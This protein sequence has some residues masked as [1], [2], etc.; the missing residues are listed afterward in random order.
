MKPTKR[1]S[2]KFYRFWLYTLFLRRR[3]IKLK[4]HNFYIHRIPQP[5]LI[6][7]TL[8]LFL[9]LTGVWIIKSTFFSKT[10]AAGD[11]SIAWDFSV[12]GDYT[13]S[14]EN[15]VEVQSSSAR[16]KIREYEGDAANTSV[17]FNFNEA[18]GNP[19]DSSTN[20][21][22]AT[23]TNVTYGSGKLN[24][25]AIFSGN[26]SYVEV[27]DSASISLS[28]S[29]TVE[30]WIKLDANY[31]AGSSAQ[32]MG[33]LDK[34]DY[35]FGFNNETGKLVY[36]FADSGATDWS[37]SAAGLSNGSWDHNGKANIESSNF[38]GGNLYA[39][40][41][42]AQGDAEVWKWDGTTWTKIGGDAINESWAI[43]TFEAVYA[44][45]NDGTNLYVGL[46]LTAGE[47]EVWKWDGTSWSKIGGDAINNSWAIST[48]EAVYS[49][50]YQ[51]S[52]LY[53]G[54]GAGAS[55][56]EV[57]SWNG[58][59]WTKIGGDSTNS[60]WLTNYDSVYTLAG[61]G[62]NIYAGLGLT[63]TEAE[64]WK[65]NGTA[66]TKIGG[67]GLNSSW[68]TVY[69]SVLSMTYLSP[70]LYA[71]VGIT[72]S[73]GEV[74]RYDT[75]GG[76]WLQIGGDT[77]N[78][79]W[80][81]N[82]EGAYSVRT[83]G[84]D[85]YAGLGLTAADAELWKWTVATEQWSKLGGDVLNGSFPATATIV[86]TIV[87]DGSTLY[88][89]VNSG[90][91]NISGQMWRLQSGT[92]TLIG[93][94]KINFSWGT[95]GLQTVE[96][97][98][99]SEDKLYAGT[100]YSVA[101]NATVWEYDESTWN[102]VGGQG[103]NSS[104]AANTYEN[105]ISMVSHEGN[106]T[107]GLGVTAGEAEVW[108]YEDDTQTWTKV[109]GDT[110]NSSWGAGYEEV[111]SLSS[112]N[113]TLYAGIGITANDAE[114]WA[115]T[116]G[117]WAKI[118]GDT[119][120]SSWGAGYERVTSIQPYKGELYVGLG[121]TV[122]DAE[123]WKWDGTIWSRVGGDGVN[124]S[125]ANT[126]YESVDSMIIYGNYLAIGLGTGAGESEVWLYDGTNFTQI[127]GD[128]LNSSWADATY[129]RVRALVTYN[130]DLY[131]GTGNGTGEGE[132][133]K[134]NGTSWTQVGGDDFHNGWASNIEEIVSFSIYKGK[135]YA[136]TG[137]TAN[138]D[139]NVWSYG[140]NVHVESTTDTFDTN[141]HHVAAVYNG[142]TV[143]LYIDGVLNN[144][145]S[146]VA[147]I[148][149][150][151]KSLVIG[152]TKAG[153]EAGKPRGDFEGI[154]DEL[155]ISNTARNISDLITTPYT[156]D[157][158]TIRPTSPVMTS[159]I[160]NW[161]EF[162]VTDG[163]IGD[164]KF[165]LSSDAGATWKYWTGAAWATSTS[166]SESTSA[167]TINS[168]I[169][170][171]PVTNQGILWQGV[172][173]GNGEEL[174]SITNVEIRATRDITAPTTPNTLTSLS[175]VGGSTITSDNWY[176]HTAPNFSF[177]GS[178][179]TGGS[180]ISGYYVYFGLDNTADPV[181]AGGFQASSTYTPSGLVSGNTYYL[182]VK[183][184]DNA[185][186]VS[187]YP[188]W[189]PYIYKFDNVNPTNPTSISVSPSG[190]A[191]T[192]NFTFSWPAG[193]DGGSNLS[194]YQY[195]TGA[196]SGPLSEW[197]ATITD[198]SIVIA[199]AAYQGDTNVFYLRTIDNTGNVAATP[200]QTN[201]YFAGE[202]PTAPK[203]LTA[204]PSENTANSFAFSWQ[205]PDSYSGDS[206]DLTYC[207]T[208]NTLPSLASCNYTSA[209]ATSLSA[210]SFATQVGTNTFYVVAKNPALSGGTINY[211]AYESV[212]FTANT[213]APGIPLNID[214]SDISIKSTSTW[215]LT[216][217]W[218]TPED[219][220]SGVSDYQIYR[221]TDGSSFSYLATTS[222]SAYVDTGLIQQAYYYQVKA[223]DSV[224][225]CGAATE[226]V[227]LI[228]TGKFTEAAALSSDPVI[229]NITT[230]KATITWGTDRTS[231]SKIQ[232]GT[233]SDN[234]FDEE[235]SNSDQVT[236]HTI[237]LSNLSPGT[238]YYSIAKW[239]DEDGNTG[240]SEDFTFKTLPAPII[241]EAVA[242]NIGINSVV[243]K[244]TVSGA[245]KV[246]IYFGETTAFGGVQEV[247][248]GTSESTYTVILDE[249]KDGVKYFFKVNPLDTEDYEYD[250]QVNSFETLPR[251]RISNVRVQQVKGTAQPTMLVSWDTNTE[252]S[253]IVTYYPK[254]NTSESRD[255]VNTSLIS[256]THKLLVKGLKTQTEYQLVA[257]GRDLA[258]N[259]ASSDPQTFTTST[260]T[261]PPSISD[262]KIE[263]NT[264]R[265]G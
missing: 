27:A 210:S 190:Y 125:W 170:T 214:I 262:L 143:S 172:L 185:Q 2:S 124:S 226:E 246:K 3:L 180:G 15:L 109:G 152:T 215:R 219:V 206:D 192:N 241:K 204:S 11:T 73:E 88:A 45:A 183:V 8:I 184:V 249:L 189:D 126:T 35:Q 255:E 243:L 72:A 195:K 149:D 111:S 138:A 179:D 156:A 33:I 49:L 9:S 37:Q 198:T 251:P 259:E 140:E 247:A 191:A 188:N 237:S 23:E 98:N 80:G 153:R 85:I 114:V 233:S 209:G 265:S 193:S 19:D 139:A 165:R 31:S 51:N 173:D 40:T 234:Y 66:W 130:G 216:V 134:Y 220:G 242:A 79:G 174:V 50:Y 258:G 232:Y 169:S 194:G 93:Q 103:V 178:T 256:G 34:G 257:K 238:T 74:W 227:T 207:Y 75:V 120:N 132:V 159:Q 121:S 101:G 77:L 177:A 48:Y 32:R 212:T 196:S 20:N 42:V 39:G 263:G 150:S 7:V 94:D 155:R 211:G 100:G 81:A 29:H 158:Q 145:V 199:D 6:S 60:G 171:F 58:S 181:T 102:I 104:W 202:G 113:G 201:Y 26:N 70:Y 128:D 87:F 24:N 57:W 59:T 96:V 68:N 162:N 82:Y 208:V 71:G 182:R 10:F 65:W 248:T 123:L 38:F 95:R 69:E 61:D 230:R 18:S 52:T 129:E 161:D 142:S 110:V 83:D 21:N 168:N 4:N 112:F 84:T 92:W 106:I 12:T 131:A 236:D 235:P 175:S 13:V 239:T 137:N 250:N 261:R 105:V 205:I 36:Q 146:D 141:W 28:G 5:R 54:L 222:G 14:D 86:N 254:G 157:Q 197:S 30:A 245:S 25:G 47:G 107:V 16:L 122:G 223:C 78:L 90:N 46:G 200:V 118:G 17:L 218:N 41:G 99:V 67:D 217:S 147:T 154:I 89:G 97:M 115:Y 253:S 213:S 62:T 166:L 229:S 176:S 144:S 167:A 136:G 91:A 228:P 44:M 116:S 119:A 252:T 240:Q 1:I 231:D 76:T 225:N 55:D 135:L 160:K 127:G 221:S 108:A 63:A 203:F 244:F 163:G 148:P 53:A 22:S 224:D 164:V 43:N 187:G 64:V 56:A 260:D 133:W 264:I 117:T 186:N 151:N